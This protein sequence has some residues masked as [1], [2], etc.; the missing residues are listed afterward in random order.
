MLGTNLTLAAN[1][2]RNDQVVAMPTETVYGLAG[3][4]MS[5]TA[6]ARIFEAKNRP[7]FDPLIVHIADIAQVDQ[8]ATSV[9]PTARK[10][11][12]A[13]WP[14][15]LT[16]LLPKQD[17]VPDLV[18]SSLPEVGLRM[19][20]HPLALELIRTAGVPVAAPSANLFGR[21]SPTTAQHVED[22]LGDRIDYILDGGPCQVG[23]ESTIIR[24]HDDKIEVLRFG[25]ITIEDLH[26]ATGL[27]VITATRTIDESTGQPMSAPGMLTSHYAPLTPLVIADPEILEGLVRMNP[28]GIG[29]LLS[30]HLCV[31][32]PDTIMVE[33][34]SETGNLVEM[35]ANFF[36]ALRRLDS[37][38][39]IAIYATPFPDRGL[40]R[41][42]N[43]RLE[44]A[45]AKTTGI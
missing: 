20:N 37:H 17:T 34:L 8:L 42:L 5:S 15:P 12:T 36:A 4:A 11:M 44:R 10:L 18:T 38:N 19:P 28:V 23:V 16:I 35:A 32:Y 33:C 27:P 30:E 39:L 45:A 2:L 43:D 40:G 13:F 3:N 21:I 7:L 9:S 22:Q 41:A 25:G 29:L 31:R 1:L 26:Q 6:V 24:A 14:G